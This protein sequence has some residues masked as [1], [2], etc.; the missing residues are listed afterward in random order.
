MET[1][2]ILYIDDNVD[3]YISQYLYDEYKYGNIN[4]EYEQLN[5]QSSDTYESMLNDVL[6]QAADII[7]IDSMLFEN[8][9]L[10]HEK[11]AGEELGVILK[12]VFPFKKVIIVTQNDI[13]EECGV[14]KKYDT[15]LEESSKQF[16]DAEWKPLLDEAIEDILITRKLLKRIK[17]KNY[18]EKYLFEEIQQSLQGEVGYENL[19]VEDIDKLVEAFESVKKEYENK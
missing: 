15:S 1:I 2:R 7:I 9:N 12:K 3:A 16:F 5:F 4:T 13:I 18:V 19:T 6:V 10:S 8:A 17:E 11:L 14:I